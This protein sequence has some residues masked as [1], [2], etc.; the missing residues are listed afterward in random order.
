MNALTQDTAAN[1]EE[2]AAAAEELSTQ[3]ELMEELVDRFRLEG[4]GRQRLMK[5]TGRPAPVSA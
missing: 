2:S 3:A 1:S 4:A 5:R